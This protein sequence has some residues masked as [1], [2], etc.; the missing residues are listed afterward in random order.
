V[1]A[2]GLAAAMIY[3]LG[4]ALFGEIA[5]ILAAA[6]LMSSPLFWFYG[7]AGLPY[8]CDTLI[9][10]VAAWL[11]WRL[12][13]GHGRVLLPLALWLGLASGLRLWAALLMVP[14][15]IFAAVQA[16]RVESLR[17]A[18]L[19]GSLL[20]GS[21][22]GLV[23]LLSIDR[24]P[25]S[26]PVVQPAALPGS[27]S[28]FVLIVGWG[29]ALAALPALGMLPLWALRIPGFRSS[30]GR[31]GWLR[32]AHVQFFAAW[33]LPWLL[34]AA[35]IRIDWL[36]Q[37]AVGLPI[38]LLWSASALVRFISAGTRRM[39]IVATTLIILGNAA[40]FLAMP[41]RQMLGG[42]RLPCAATI[43]YHDRRLAAAI[44]AIRSFSPSETVIIAD[45]WLPVRLYLP[46]YPLIPYRHADGQPDD[47]VDLAPGQRE[48]ARQSA[49]LV[50]FE[51][52]LDRYNASPS[53]TEIQPLA[54]GT[55]R[56]LRPQPAEE[57]VVDTHRF[58]LRIKPQ[59][60]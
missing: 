27:I 26:L 2:S 38:L 18:Q 23:W 45:E 19:I 17:P 41:E 28:N 1:A 42:H 5:G 54:A 16:I 44:V 36:G 56:L 35:L 50:W 24:L 58:G 3:L 33:G 60:R 29:W 25:S 32:D 11:C 10:I 22:L 8:A 40:L 59:R 15:A 9:A 7:G 55:L 39:A 13:R 52:T 12:A 20:A 4:A 47:P 21:A 34:S 57:L 53:E 6:L 31:W 43:F 46:A 37:P 51:V 49:A 48:Q 30:Y 14:L